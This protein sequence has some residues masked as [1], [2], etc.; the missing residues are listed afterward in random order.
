MFIITRS[1]SPDFLWSFD[2]L[3]HAPF[4]HHAYLYLCLII[5]LGCLIQMGEGTE[6]EFFSF[7]TCGFFL[8]TLPAP[9]ISILILPV[10][11]SSFST[12]TPSSHVV[13]PFHASY[14]IQSFCILPSFCNHFLVVLVC[15]ALFAFFFPPSSTPSDL[16]SW[17]STHVTPHPL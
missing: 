7:I 11:L 14:W 5:T 12:S 1:F 15:F 10:P 9:P 4:F 8:H 16:I 2:L 6:C 3:S 13:L 17:K